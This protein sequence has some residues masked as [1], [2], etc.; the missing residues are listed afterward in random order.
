MPDGETPDAGGGK[1]F[2][3]GDAFIDIHADGTKAARKAAADIKAAKQDFADA[4]DEVGDVAGDHAG[5]KMAATT[6]KKAKK[7]LADAADEIGDDAGTKI[8][9]KLGDSTAKSAKK[10]I[11]AEGPKLGK[12]IAISVFGGLP[13]AAQV[14][15]AAAALG[16]AGAGTAIIGLAALATAGNQDTQASYNRL[17]ATVRD[18]T[19]NA[20]QPLAAS[21]AQAA[22]D[23]NNQLQGMGGSFQHLFAAAKPG[24]S[25][26]EGGLMG[27]VRGALP[28]FTTAVEHSGDAFK[29]LS[30]LLTDTGK[31][32]GLFFTNSAQAAQSSGVILASFGRIIRDLLGFAGAFFAQ[33]S[34]TGAGAAVRFE[35]VLSQLEGTLLRLGQGAFPVMFAA[36]GVG[37]NVL[38]GLLSIMSGFAPV[39]G[40]LIGTVLSA[41]AAFKLIDTL[42]FGNVGKQFDAFKA[43]VGAADGAGGKFKAGMTNLMSTGLGPMAIAIGVAIPVLSMFGA[44]QERAAKSAQQHA[45]N[46]ESLSTALRENNGVVNGNVRSLAAKDLQNTKALGS[47]KNLLQLAREA[48][49][50]Q[51]LLTDAYLGS[52]SAQD[53]VNSAL[54]A[55]IDKGTTKSITDQGIIET[56]DA[57]AL[58]AGQLQSEMNGVNSTFGTAVQKNKDL[59]AAA[60]ATGSD[61]DNL[62]GATDRQKKATEGLRGAFETLASPMGDVATRGKAIADAFDRL[63]GRQP[64]LEE[65]TKNW[66]QFMD[67]LKGTKFEDAAHGTKKWADGLVEANGQINTTTKDGRTLYDLVATGRKN[68]DELA[69]AMSKAGVPAGEMQVRLQGMRDE[70]LKT[71]EKLGFTKAEAKAMADQFGLLPS[72]VSILMSTGGTISATTAE[73][74]IL[75]GKL[76]GLPTHTPVVVDA[77]TEQARQLLTDM[78]IQVRTLPNGKVSV[79]ADT[80]AAAKNLEDFMWYWKRRQLNI[81]VYVQVFGN[82]LKNIAGGMAAAAG[83]TDYA[84]GGFTLVGEEGPEIVDLPRGSKVYTATETRH[85]LDGYAAGAGPSMGGGTTT[86]APPVQGGGG[87]T[88]ITNHWTVTA[89]PGPDLNALTEMLSR[90]IE[91]RMRQGQGA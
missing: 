37:L 71:I 22:D 2:K 54:Q 68:F 19:V 87:N 14:A 56:T 55:A 9:D 51:N 48:G 52:A 11:D 33:L 57:T 43:A 76:H 90:R 7:G 21:F 38:S 36:A 82:Q 84:P 28:G 5:T 91:L 6:K 81:P 61:I 73:T 35:Q 88:Y 24:I 79:E 31:G 74:M 83:G 85:M 16:L 59:A 77:L 89:P 69:A 67:D 41:V 8:G 58:A 34:N 64:D 40:P 75:A 65:T 30:S 78:G 80:S 44:A 29:G 20:A 17:F 27:L 72:D 50:S 3:M 62:R 45:D 49:V 42:S 46:V 13:A 10:K 60:A 53:Q 4:G 39:L 70:L 47:E 23:I 63:T 1:G 12:W 86:L 15:G 26:L 32:I 18:G 25:A 66:H